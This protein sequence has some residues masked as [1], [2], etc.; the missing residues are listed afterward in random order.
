MMR[1]LVRC[2]G[3]GQRFFENVP[4]KLGWLPVS[5]T[6]PGEVL[7]HEHGTPRSAGNTPPRSSGML[8][9]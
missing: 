7:Q 5:G 3:M 2:A 4:H 9:H 1:S 8:A 6:E